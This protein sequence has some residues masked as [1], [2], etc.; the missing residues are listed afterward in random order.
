MV[1]AR[2]PGL[3]QSACIGVNVLFFKNMSV[4]F[5]FGLMDAFLL[6]MA[7]FA[8]GIHRAAGDAFAVCAVRIKQTVGMMIFIWPLMRPYM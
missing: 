8:D 2:N 7:G 5:V 1:H 3:A 6:N 4:H